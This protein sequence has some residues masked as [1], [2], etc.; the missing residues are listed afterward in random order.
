MQPHLSTSGALGKPL[1][2]LEAYPRPLFL[3]VDPVTSSNITDN[4]A[5][6]CT[7]VLHLI[8]SLIKYVIECTQQVCLQC[9]AYLS[10]AFRL[11]N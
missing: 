4:A 7:S 1:P 9:I 6:L 2:P 8:V 10:C 5:A 11:H 3:S